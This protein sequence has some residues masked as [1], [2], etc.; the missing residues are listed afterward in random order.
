MEQAELLRKVVEVLEKLNIPY[1]VT[2]SLATTLYG[3][4]RFTNDI[5]VVIDLAPQKASQLAANFPSPDF[6]L[7]D[8]AIRWAIQHR[9]QFNIIH[10][11][12]GLKVDMMIS[13]DTPFEKGRFARARRI[14]PA[15]EYEAAF[16][17][18]E[19]IIVKKMQFYEEGGS[20]KHL[21]DVASVLTILG[22]GIDRHYIE[23]WARHFHV[24]QIW[25]TILQRL[26][27]R[28]K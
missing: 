23:Q 5:D 11:D 16:S 7:S 9:S 15:P 1:F 19:D 28:P 2:G 13:G 17:S 25:Q 20:E 4:P 24:E 26:D 22:D 18:P 27:S 14:K 10:P 8:D 21:R 12:S 6:Y 3:E